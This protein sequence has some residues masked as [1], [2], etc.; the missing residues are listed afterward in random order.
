MRNIIIGKTYVTQAVIE[1]KEKF[2]LFYAQNAARVEHAADAV[3]SGWVARGMAEHRFVVQSNSECGA[4]YLVDRQVSSCECK[5]STL[6]KKICSHRISVHLAVRALELER[7][8]D[9]WE[10]TIEAWWLARG[11]D[12]EEEEILRVRLDKMEKGAL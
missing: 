5:W 7:E 6:Q 12:S 3:R 9:E 11:V 8:Y 1:L 4:S 2:P 10:R